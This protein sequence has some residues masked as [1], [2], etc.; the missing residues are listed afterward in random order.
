MEAEEITIS[1]EAEEYLEAIYRLEKKTG[2]AKT[3]ELARQLK[4]VPGSVTNTIESLERR[5]FVI[6]EP[7]RGVK[8]TEKGRKL[9]LN[10]L[11]RHRL[12]ERLLTDILHLDWSEA[13]EA[14]CKLEHAIAADIIKPLEKALGHP[15]TCPHG[16]P[17]PT[18]C[19]GMIEQKSEP[20]MNLNPKESGI[21]V[22]ITEEERSILHHL[23]TLGL[24]PGVSVEVEQ[25]ASFGDPLTVRVGEASYTLDHKVVS[26]INV[27]RADE[28][29]RR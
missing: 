8:L 21:I 3:M 28:S 9:A 1:S 26:V 12:A 18:A 5:G 25:K 23:A 20:L 6:H 10:V 16:N 22:K 29:E 19:G 15:K 7:Y 11:R 27:R 4:V 2:F 13:H 14:A 24:M 17:I